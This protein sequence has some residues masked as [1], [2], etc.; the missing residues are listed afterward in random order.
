LNTTQ[1]NSLIMSCF[2]IFIPITFVAL[3]SGASIFGMLFAILYMALILPLPLSDSGTVRYQTVPWVTIL[4]IILNTILLFW[5]QGYLDAIANNNR[6][7]ESGA[8]DATIEKYINHL[9]IY[10]IRSRY[11]YE[12]YSVGAFT[13]I[14]SVC[15]HGGLFHLIG[16]MVFLWSFGRRLEDAC[17]HWR[18]LIYYLI[19]GIIAGLGSIYLSPPHPS[20]WDVPSIGASGAVFGVM[21]AYLILFPTS[22]IQSLWLPGIFLLRPLIMFFARVFEED[23]YKPFRW[24]VNLPSIIVIGLYAFFNLRDAGEIIGG[25]ELHNAGGTLAHV[26]GFLASILIFLFVRKDLLRRYIK[27]RNL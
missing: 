20:G 13:S 12:A 9:W 21:G 10:G 11:I 25:A 17:G 14:T 24:L 6:M 5:W 27:G 8:T 7:M 18:F 23:N 3:V 26:T 15:M 2:I 19:A 4:I 16:N 22:R 1:R